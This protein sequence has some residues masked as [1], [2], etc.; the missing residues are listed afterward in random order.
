[1]RVTIASRIFGPEPSAAS[2]RLEALANAFASA[3]H[4][5][6][7]LTVRS[8][9]H[10]SSDTSDECHDFRVRRFPVLRDKSGYVR[11]YVQYLSFDVPLFFRILFGTKQ[12]LIVVEPPPTTGFFS[13]IASWLK[14]TPYAYYAAD[15]WADAASQTGAPGWMVTAVRRIETFAW[16]GAATVL[17]VSDG[18]TTRLAE[19]G[20]G[21]AVT[22][23]GNGVVVDEFLAGIAAAARPEKAPVDQAPVFVYAG[24]ASEW[25]GAGVFIEALP[26]V[27]R[28]VPAAQ[29]R[30]IG[31]GSEREALEHRAAELGVA[32]AVR[33]DPPMGARELGPILRDAAAAIASV[34]PGAGYDFAFPTKLYSAAVCGAPLIYSGVGPAVEFVQRRVAGEAI[35]TALPLDAARVA[36]AMIA[37][38][39]EPVDEARR[40]RISEWA[41]NEVSLRAVS[42]RAVQALESA[43][44]R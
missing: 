23:I 40:I 31:G 39:N 12:D 35:G 14:R 25:H 38:A 29:L 2:F 27:R 42:Q 10:L 34:R 7:V 30:F 16:R 5:V 19:L 37:C 28:A 8:P 13:R 18:V 33:F 24:T 43:L 11:G 9:K 6:T 36:D 21:R 15:I 20:M 3:G 22:T 17:S 26:A 1:M 44:K 4:E 32:D 41:A